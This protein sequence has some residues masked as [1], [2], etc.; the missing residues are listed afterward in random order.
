MLPLYGIKIYHERRKEWVIHN[1][2]HTISKRP[3]PIH[4]TQM[5]MKSNVW[6]FSQDELL[7][8]I[9]CFDMLYDSHVYNGWYPSWFFCQNGWSLNLCCGYFPYNAYQ[10]SNCLWSICNILA[11]WEIEN[12][13]F[14]F[15][16]LLHS[17]FSKKVFFSLWKLLFFTRWLYFVILLWYCKM[18]S[19]GQQIIY[20]KSFCK[21]KNSFQCAWSTCCLLNSL[22]DTLYSGHFARFYCANHALKEIK[23]NPHLHKLFL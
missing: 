16:V 17:C 23:V 4:W 9:L 6:H 8:V 3:H 12:S 20:T 13:P 14:S 19:N 11:V 1:K 2:L 21:L 10:K 7:L 15:L 5:A 22:L 18:A